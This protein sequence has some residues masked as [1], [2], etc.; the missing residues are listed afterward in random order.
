MSLPYARRAGIDT[1]SI[2][3]IGNFASAEGKLRGGR[4]TASVL[5]IGPFS[6]NNARIIVV[7]GGDIPPLLTV[8]FTQR[9]DINI[10][11]KTMTISSE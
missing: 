4:I 6:I 11:G 7:D 5:R 10:R 1:S 3:W 8:N 2:S 9:Y